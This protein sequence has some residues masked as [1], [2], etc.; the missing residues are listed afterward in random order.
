[1]AFWPRLSRALEV[2]RGRLIVWDRCPIGWQPNALAPVFYGVRDELASFPPRVIAAASAHPG[3]PAPEPTHRCRV[4]F[5]SLDGSPETARILAGCGRYPAVVFAHGHCFKDAEHYKLWN[6]L[7]AELAR[8]GYVV[9]VPELLQIGGG[10]AP[11]DADGDLELLGEFADWLRTRWEHRATVMPLATGL[12]G[13]SRGAGLAG[14]LAARGGIAAFASL[15]GQGI[16]GVE[17]VRIPKL[18][19]WGSDPLPGADL[20]SALS[21][22][23]W[24]GMPRPKH[25]AVLDN[26]GHFDYIPAGRT[27]CESESPRGPCALTPFLAAELLVMFFGRYLRPERT[28]GPPARIASSLLPPRLADL[29]LS[30]EQQFFA[31]GFL[32]AFEGIGSSSGCRVTLRWET[33][34]AG[35]GTLVRP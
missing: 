4:F 12:V 25:S 3:G 16:A 29:G 28:P 34:A 27:G 11:A 6:E 35:S 10:T 15:S 31:G 17:S 1:M 19:M 8:C 18:F 21:E 20:F 13:H 2:I 23:A 14:R 33:D 26:I 30:T 22:T 24:A 7:P 9:V 5:P 32:G